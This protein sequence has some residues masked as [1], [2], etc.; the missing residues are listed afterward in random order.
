MIVTGPRKGC[1]CFVRLAR[2]F[3]QGAGKQVKPFHFERSYCHLI[4]K[5][6]FCKRLNHK[7]EY[8]FIRYC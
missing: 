4:I 8:K 3:Q 1:W 7:M 5:S 2:Q 6:K